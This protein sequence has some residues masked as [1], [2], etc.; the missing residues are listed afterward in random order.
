MGLT[1]IGWEGVD[2]IYLAQNKAQWHALVNMAT[3]LG[4]INHGNLTSLASI[5]FSVM[6]LLYRVR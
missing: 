5:S 2:M 6:P 1:E 4:S 3:K